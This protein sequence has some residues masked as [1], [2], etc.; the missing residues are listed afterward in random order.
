MS[1]ILVIRPSWRLKKSRRTPGESEPHS[2]LYAIGLTIVSLRN[3][4]ASSLQPHQ[5]GDQVA[6]DLARA[7]ADH[8]EPRVAHVALDVELQREAVAAVHA[9]RVRGHLEQRLGGEEVRHGRLLHAA[10]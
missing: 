5:A 3:S 7:V 4:C 1:K 9:H 10:D 6:L 2:L 8:E